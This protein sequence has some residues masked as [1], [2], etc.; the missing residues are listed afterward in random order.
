MKALTNNKLN[1][2]GL[3]RVKMWENAAVDPAVS[4]LG[5][6]D[7]YGGVTVRQLIFIM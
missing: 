4:H 6:V 3:S 2:E 1:G 5:I 7:L